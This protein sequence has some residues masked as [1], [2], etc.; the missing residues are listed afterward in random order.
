MTDK[1]AEI[2]RHA[3]G[4]QPDYVYVNLLTQDEVNWLIAEVKWLR[5]AEQRRTEEVQT[6]MAEVVRLRAA[7]EE[8]LT[9]DHSQRGCCEVAHPER[10]AVD[11][12]AERRDPRC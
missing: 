10:Q 5:I 8:A 4:S 12:C 6:A 2:E 7:L 3:H 11:T 1:L 9:I